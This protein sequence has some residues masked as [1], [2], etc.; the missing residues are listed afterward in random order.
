MED[1]AFTFNELLEETL[2]VVANQRNKALDDLANQAAEKK[3]IQDELEDVRASYQQLAEDYY[4]L[5]EGDVLDGFVDK[6]N[7]LEQFIEVQELHISV[8]TNENAELK[9]KLSDYENTDVPP[10]LPA[11][12][13]E[14][15]PPATELNANN[16][17]VPI[18]DETPS[19][20]VVVVP[21]PVEEQFPEPPVVEETPVTP[22]PVIEVATDVISDS[23][24]VP[25]VAPEATIE[26]V[27]LVVEQPVEPTPLP[28]ALEAI[29]EVIEANTLPATIDIGDVA[30]PAP[31]PPKSIEAVEE[32]TPLTDNENPL[33]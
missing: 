24:A 8:I 30:Q 4:S 23:V 1:V 11:P 13:E 2:N 6:I 5:W 22:T 32:V 15:V 9:A 16:E 33:V 31:E 18:P 3:L 14:V 19:T 10:A 7:N 21:T 25:P 27:P 12:I 26:D 29:S 20:E 17:W 28:P